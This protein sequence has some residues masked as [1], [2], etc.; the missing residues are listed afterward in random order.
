MAD[1]LWKF[2]CR[3]ALEWQLE[4]AAAIYPIAM[5]MP[6]RPRPTA[7][8]YV[9]FGFHPGPSMVRTLG[10]HPRIE[11]NGFAKIGVFTKAGISQDRNDLI[12][13]WVQGVF[14][15]GTNLDRDGLRVVVDACDHSDFVEVDGWGY[16][17]VDVNWTVWRTT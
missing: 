14:P 2:D 1:A 5:M 3:K 16:S 13:A 17:P 4:Q 7:D 8:E 6:G 10:T 9:R 12:A 11:S 15:Y